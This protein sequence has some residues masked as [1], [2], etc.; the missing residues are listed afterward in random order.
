MSPALAVKNVSGIKPSSAAA[1]PNH[2][3]WGFRL[4]KNRI[5]APD[6]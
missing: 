4:E 6:T 1:A 2:E 5:L 3:P